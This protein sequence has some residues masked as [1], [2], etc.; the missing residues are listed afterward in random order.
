MKNKLTKFLK[1]FKD[2]TLLLKVTSHHKLRHYGRLKSP[3]QK[4]IRLLTKHYQKRDY[5]E[6]IKDIW[7]IITK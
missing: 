5:K 7:K 1:K 3:P 6:A 2:K 4:T